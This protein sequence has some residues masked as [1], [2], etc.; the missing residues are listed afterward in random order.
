LRD[1][2]LPDLVALA[3][4]RPA[5]LVDPADAMLAPLRPEAC[6]TTCAWPLDIYRELGVPDHMRLL[7]T[8]QGSIAQ[9]AEA[10]AGALDAIGKDF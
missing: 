2:D 1:F 10:V 9:V 4:P 6:Q 5:F 3:A 8:A 7:H